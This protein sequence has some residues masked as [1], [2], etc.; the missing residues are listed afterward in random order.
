MNLHI[1]NKMKNHWI[2]KQGAIYKAI[3][4]FGILLLLFAACKK[5]HTEPVKEALKI[6]DYYPNSGNKGTLVTVE[7]TGLGGDVSA[8]FSGT[9]A[10]IVSTTTTAV[11]MRAPAGG[12]SGDIVMK[13]NGE[14]VNIGKYTYQELT[15]KGISPKNGAAGT[16]IRISGEGFGSQ[17]GP[18]EVFI[19]GKTALVVSASDTL[20]VAEVPEEAG[21]GA[22]TV[23]VNGKEAS[24]QI[25]K[26]QSITAIKPL[27]G[28][29]GTRVRI[30]G[31]GFDELVKGNYVDFNGKQ[32]LVE[33]AADDHLIVVTPDA[34]GTGPVSVTINNQK[35]TGP[36]F[37]VVALPVILNVTPLSGPAGVV[38]TITGTTFSTITAENK[39]T[40]NGKDVAVTAA[41]S[42]KIT[43]TVPGGTGNGK[44]VLSV[45]D[46]LTE[47]PEFK[48]QS[49]G[50]SKLSPESG[51]AGTRVTIIGTGFSTTAGQNSVT[52]NG[53]AATVVSALETS[54]VVI[55]PEGFSSGPLKVVVNGQTTIA[56][57]NFNHAGVITLA[58]G[59]GN[60]ELTLDGRSGALAVDGRGN[61]YVLE[62]ALNRVKKI[63]PDGTVSLFAGSPS[64]QSGDKNGTG[65]DAMFSF[66]SGTGMAID[67][68]DNL[69]VSDYGNQTIRKITSQGIVSTFAVNAGRPN[70]IAFDEKG[71]LYVINGFNNVLRFDKSG[72][73][74]TMKSNGLD[75][76]ARPAI[77]GDIFYSV[78]NETVYIGSSEISGARNLN[79]WVGTNYGYADGIGTAAMFTSINGLTSDGKGN[80]LVA[81][82]GN[83]AIRKVN[84]A[85]REVTTVA[86]FSGGAKDGSLSEAGFSNIGDIA[87][88]KDGNI[89]VVDFNN[90]AVRKIFLK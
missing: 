7:G 88:D 48:D 9:N 27:T 71:F 79:W 50:I 80:I 55:A 24:G 89:Y 28:G 5:D 68:Q 49:L 26:F 83:L 32:A 4:S 18:A 15:I 69:Y 77:F 42:T 51:L 70:K 62:L 31:S 19:N 40:I 23:K 35:V 37:T 63:T 84:I 12:T 10:D 82:N 87:I 85:T 13:V 56:P 53:K 61:V 3:C 52:F 33:E 16:H 14:T 21:S 6:I 8:T 64:G 20:L 22:V 59:K 57:I 30:T 44:I 38:M 65:S 34:V 36:V 74:S 78:S 47:G 11:V 58:G 75:E 60:T 72:L 29:K 86:K 45:N 90:N 46:Q 17:S 81:D 66:N 25:F 67:N 76:S 39:V 73:R 2:F 54:L 1:K 43:L 41:T